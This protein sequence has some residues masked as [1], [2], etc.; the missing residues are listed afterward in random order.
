MCH[1][2]RGTANAANLVDASLILRHSI[3]KISSRNPESG[4]KYDYKMFAF[5][6]PQ[7]EGCSNT[8]HDLGFE[9]I[10][11]DH[12]VRRDEMAS[13]DQRQNI[14]NEF[15]CGEKEF[16]KLS[17]WTL[18]AELI[19]HLDIDFMFMKPMDHLFDAILYDKYSPEGTAAREKVMLELDTNYNATLPDKIGAFITRDW[20]QVAPNK[21]PPGC[22]FR[23]Y[24]LATFLIYYML[25]PNSYST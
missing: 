15:C 20:H 9:I 5:V 13:E 7:A 25:V 18:P 11:V 19:V 24:T 1:D 17:A 22:K 6:H 8:L 14:R 21:W 10:L 12:P 16:I 3:H 2:F 23:F 4:S